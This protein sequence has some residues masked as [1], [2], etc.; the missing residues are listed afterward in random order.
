M[1]NVRLPSGSH[2]GRLRRPTGP[3]VTTDAKMQATRRTRRAF[4]A[5]RHERCRR[6]AAACDASVS[7]APWLCGS[8]RSCLFAAVSLWLSFFV[9]L[10]FLRVFVVPARGACVV[11]SD[12]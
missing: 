4:S 6:E 1:S 12:L 11:N 3:L 8:E 7:A 9:R 2:V 10:R 5:G